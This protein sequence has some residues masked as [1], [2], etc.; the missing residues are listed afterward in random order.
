MNIKDLQQENTK[1]LL[2]LIGNERKSDSV[3][4]KKKFNV[5]WGK[6][7]KIVL[8]EERP[9]P[10]KPKEKVQVT[11]EEKIKKPM[12]KEENKN[13]VEFVSANSLPKGT[14]IR[15]KFVPPFKKEEP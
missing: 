11:F 12:K 2:K 8:K 14:S 4:D 9:E 13:Q 1:N 6:K 10:I 15:K 7:E 5:K 3:K